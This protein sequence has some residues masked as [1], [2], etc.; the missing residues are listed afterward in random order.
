VEAHVAGNYATAMREFRPLAEQGDAD[1]QSML[2][3]MYALGKG[4]AQDDAQALKRLCKLAG[5]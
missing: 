4:V 5:Y 2:G 1:A 3:V